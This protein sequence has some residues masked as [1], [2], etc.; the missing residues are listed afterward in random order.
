MSS[1]Y[2]RTVIRENVVSHQVPQSYESLSLQVPEL[3][4]LSSTLYQ[5]VMDTSLKNCG[6]IHVS[7]R[8]QMRIPKA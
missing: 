6:I 7:D 1:H 3:G 2:S 8:C 4:I 5:V